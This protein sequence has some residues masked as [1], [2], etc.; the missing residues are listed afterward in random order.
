[1]SRAF[2]WFHIALYVIGLPL[3]L[4]YLYLCSSDERLENLKDRLG[5]LYEDLC[6]E[7]KRSALW[8]YPHFTLRRLS[9][10]LQSVYW[11]SSDYQFH[12]LLLNFFWSTLMLIY[13][14]HLKPFASAQTTLLEVFNEFM[15]M[16]VTVYLLI[17]YSLISDLSPEVTFEIGWSFIV[18]VVGIMIPINLLVCVYNVVRELW[19]K[20]K[21]ICYYFKKVVL[22]QTQVIRLRQEIT[23]T[24]ATEENLNT[25]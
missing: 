6:Y 22:R 12:N 20:R 7:K 3:F 17:G 18:A 16:I 19:S 25:E 8:Y 5:V 23:V 24:N 10:I 11:S 1:M 15:V 14:L 13:I 4:A 21:R 9:F 2:A